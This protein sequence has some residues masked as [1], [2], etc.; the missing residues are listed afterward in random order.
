[1]EIPDALPE[2]TPHRVEGQGYEGFEQP[3]VAGLQALPAGNGGRGSLD[4]FG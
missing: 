1:M 3:D 2:A 4:A